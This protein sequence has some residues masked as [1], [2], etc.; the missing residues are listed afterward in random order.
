MISS[1]RLYLRHFKSSD[2]MDLY[3]Y[4]SDPEVVCYEPY[5]PFTLKQCKAEAKTRSTLDVF[6]AVCLKE[7]DKVIGNLY[8]CPGEFDSY[9]LG[10]V[11]NRQ[12]QK[13]G[14]ATEICKALFHY[15]FHEMNVRRIIALCSTENTNSWRLLERLH[16]RKEG[17]FLQNVSF[18]KDSK[19]KPIYYDSY[20]YAIL[21]HE[22]DALTYLP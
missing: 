4:L 14:Y 12:F 13:Q 9:E 10:Y 17:Y 7:S 15:A 19:G 21:K 1:E 22:Y 2:Y 6:W 16:M 20:Q 5:E 18:K 3:E 11:F 8:F